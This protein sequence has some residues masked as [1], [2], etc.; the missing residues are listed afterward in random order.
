MEFRVLGPLEIV[1]DGRPVRVGPAK[2]RVILAM[3]LI[4]GGASGCQAV[5]RRRRSA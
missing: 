2:Q 5:P 1:A 4:R 3:L